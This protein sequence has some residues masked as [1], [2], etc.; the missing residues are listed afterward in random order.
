MATS[1]RPAR[2]GGR[3]AQ[4]IGVRSVV[5]PEIDTDVLAGAI[6]EMVKADLAAQ[7]TAKRQESEEPTAGE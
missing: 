3:G 2:I 6:I 1:Q 7:L 5:Q 4:S